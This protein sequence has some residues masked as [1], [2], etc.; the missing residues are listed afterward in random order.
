MRV[1][2]RPVVA[3]L[4]AAVA[5]AAAQAPAHAAFNGNYAPANWTFTPEGNVGGSVNTSG[6]PGSIAITSP[7]E[8]TVNDPKPGTSLYTIVS[9]KA[10]I[11]SFNW[12]LTIGQDEALADNDPFGF[13]L[14]GVRT[15]L[16]D[17]FEADQTGTFSTTVAQG[18]TFGFYAESLDGRFGGSTTTVSNFTTAQV[19]G[20]LP[21]LGAVV[22]FRTSRKL[23]ARLRAAAAEQQD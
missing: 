13:V 6:A 15:Q 9:P 18:D 4:G 3:A 22:A 23:R 19:P 5:V 11:V 8:G 20:P 17:D 1:L 16:S 2:S 7:N 21:V 12:S 14:N 10:S